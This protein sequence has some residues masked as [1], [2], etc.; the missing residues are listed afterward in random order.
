MKVW[1]SNNHTL[2]GQPFYDI[3]DELKGKYPKNIK[4]TGWHPF[5][6]CHAVPILKTAEEIAT[7]NERIIKGEPLDD[8]S[9]NKVNNVP[10]GFASW[11]KDNAERIERA[12]SQP[13]FIRNNQG[14]VNDILQ[15]KMPQT[16]K[17]AHIVTK[18]PSLDI[19]EVNRRF[20]IETWE[21]EIIKMDMTAYNSSPISDIDLIELD[22]EMNDIFAK[23]GM[24]KLGRKIV[25]DADTVTISY[26]AERGSR[27]YIERVFG[28][29]DNARYVDHEY[30]AVDEEYQ[31]KGFSKDV[32]KAFYKQYRKNGTQYINVHANID[33]GGYCW[34][35]YGFYANDKKN[36]ER[37]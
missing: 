16:A 1:L 12:K 36:V 28:V 5:C 15:G 21:G 6:R 37:A 8:K 33:V 20:G 18:K 13:Y 22:N 31:G 25:I 29:R 26:G 10:A 3:C 19:A 2:N 24:P 35:K 4:F 27:A 30:F 11:I 9:V 17:P 7:D 32:I 23:H 14:V 34:G